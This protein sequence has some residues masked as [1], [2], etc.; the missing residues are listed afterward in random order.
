M[1]ANSG[2]PDQTRRF[3]LFADVPQKDARLIWV[4][5]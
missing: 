1:F 2:E 4:E 5:H 3:A